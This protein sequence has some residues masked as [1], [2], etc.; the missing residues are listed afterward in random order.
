MCDREEILQAT[1]EGESE[2][3]DGNLSYY[4]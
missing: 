2:I 3:F 1:A 4:F